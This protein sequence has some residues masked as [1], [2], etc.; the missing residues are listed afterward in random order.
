MKEKHLLKAVERIEI[1]QCAIAENVKCLFKS[2][3]AKTK[4]TLF[5]P[6][7]QEFVSKSSKREP[8]D[9]QTRKEIWEM[10]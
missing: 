7:G 8:V 3:V 2:P 5:K 4:K 10:I 1:S 9:S 6:A